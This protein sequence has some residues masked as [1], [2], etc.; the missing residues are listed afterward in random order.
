M[1][2]IILTEPVPGTIINCPVSADNMVVGL[3]FTPDF[4]AM[5]RHGGNLEFHFPNQG[6]VVLEGF[7]DHSP[8]STLPHMV[9]DNGS[10]LRGDELLAAMKRGEYE[11]EFHPEA[12][13]GLKDN[14]KLVRG[15]L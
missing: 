8:E 4:D 9:L 7:F 1:E 15:T 13:P 11:K 6:K 10:V 3:M 5:S 14:H 2:Q 12:M